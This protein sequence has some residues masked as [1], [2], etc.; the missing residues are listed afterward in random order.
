MSKESRG[1]SLRLGFGNGL[2]DMTHIKP[3]SNQ[4]KQTNK[5]I[6][7]TSSKLK[8]FLLQRSLS[9]NWKDSPV[10]GRKIFTNHISDKGYVAIVYKELL[11]LNNKKP[12][13][14]N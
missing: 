14:P 11:Q 6:S 10:T 8:T 3:T 7:W 9:R 4:N 12:K 13:H 2:L 1:K 5:N